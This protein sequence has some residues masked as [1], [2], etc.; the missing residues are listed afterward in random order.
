M[1]SSPG[2]D[3]NRNGI[4]GVT[5]MRHGFSVEIFH[6]SKT[7]SSLENA[8]FVTSRPDMARN[9]YISWGSVRIFV[10]FLSFQSV[11]FD[12][13]ELRHSLAKPRL[14]TLVLIYSL[15]GCIP[16]HFPKISIYRSSLAGL[17]TQSG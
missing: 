16:S 4:I 6:V 5:Q 8:I 1:D 14:D 3:V 12:H 11:N 17:R 7:T 2:G 9:L 10:L 15:F 13:M